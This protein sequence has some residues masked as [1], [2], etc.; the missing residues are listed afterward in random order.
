MEDKR[1]K[2]EKKYEKEI[3]DYK[4]VKSMDKIEIG[5]MVKYVKIEDTKKITT[6]IVV[7]K[8]KSTD[9]KDQIMLKSPSY[10]RYWKIQYDKNLI[11]QKKIDHNKEE[12][13]NP[14][15]KILKK[16]VDVEKILRDHIKKEEHI[17]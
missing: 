6:G 17:K 5:N 4:Y 13:N 2:V 9:G 12:K 1:K 11:Y 15:I 3:E 7:K 10:A 8:M 14:M 16:N